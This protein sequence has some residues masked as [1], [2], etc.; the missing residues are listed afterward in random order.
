MGGGIQAESQH[1]KPLVEVIM[2]LGGEPAPLG[3]RGVDHH[4]AELCL[5]PASGIQLFLLEQ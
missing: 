4:T 2:N 3:F 5:G 1:S